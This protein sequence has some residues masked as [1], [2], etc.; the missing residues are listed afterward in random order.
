MTNVQLVWWDMSYDLGWCSIHFSG[1]TQGHSSC[2]SE[3][4]VYNPSFL[5]RRAEPLLSKWTAM[6]TDWSWIYLQNRLLSPRNKTRNDERTCTYRNGQNCAKAFYQHWVNVK[7][8]KVWW[9]ARNAFVKCE[10]PYSQYAF[11]LLSTLRRSH[12]GLYLR[13][14]QFTMRRKSRWSKWDLADCRWQRVD[15]MTTQ[16]AIPT[17]TWRDW[18]RGS[19]IVGR[20]PMGG[21]CMS[22]GGGRGVCM[23]EYLFWTTHPHLVTR[24]GMSRSYTS[25]PPKRLRGV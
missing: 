13:H 8:N 10:N 14:D 2:L 12:R 20:A 22:W 5:R 1:E 4:A 21:R 15:N 24:S 11:P 19:Q 17:F 25:S 18:G 6:N 3:R 7:A 23:R 9:I 16:N